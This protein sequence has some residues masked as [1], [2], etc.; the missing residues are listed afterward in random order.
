MTTRLAA[1]LARGIR[2]E[3]ARAGLTHAQLAAAVGWSQT[4]V[5][6]IE[7]G[8]RVLPAE[9]LAEVCRSLGCSLGQLLAAA[10]PDDRAALGL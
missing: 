2:A 3:R 5:S 10:H 6:E 1:A 4:T 9:D 7:L 8:R